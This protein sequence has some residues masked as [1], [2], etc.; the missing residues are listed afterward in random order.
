MQTLGTG[1]GCPRRDDIQACVSELAGN[2]VQHGTPEGRDYLL[3]LIRY[4]HCLHVEVH[5][6]AGHTR[7]RTP[8][9]PPWAVSPGEARASSKSSATTGESGPKPPL[10]RPCGPASAGSRPT[11]PD[12]PASPDS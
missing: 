7:V 11:P 9:G 5:D 3:S 2:A 6:T 10:A 1:G 8:P 12:A 4:P